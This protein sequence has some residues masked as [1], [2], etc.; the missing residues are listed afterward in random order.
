MSKDIRIKKGLSIKLKGEAEMLISDAPRSKVFAIKPTDI[1]GVIP[2]LAIKA[3]DT[4]KAGDTL[5]Y[6]K[7]NE[8][9][10]FLSPVSGEVLEIHRGAKRKILDIKIS[11]TNKDEFKDFGVKNPKDLSTGEVKEQLLAGGCWP[12]IKQRP[13]DV[14]ANPSDEPKAI[15]VSGFS[16]APLSADAAFALQG[17]EDA[18][19]AGI[20]AL[21]K[22]TS[23]KVHLSV[24]GGNATFLNNVK[25]VELHQVTGKHPAGNVGVQIH[26]IDPVNQGEHVWV[27][28]P[29]DVAIIGKLFLTGNFDAS[30]VI[31][32]AGSE[33][34]SPKYYRTIQG[35]GMDSLVNG[36]LSSEHVRIVS[37][38]VL[39]GEA[40]GQNGFLGFYHNEV[41]VIPEGD[42]YK[43]F[44]WMPF[45][46]NYKFSMSRTFFSWLTP[47][48]KYSL[49]TN[50]NG[51]LRA[52]VV[53]G[54]MEK[55]LPMDIYPMQLLKA[56]L[57]KDIE[58]ME[59][60]G[61][62]EVA[63]EDFALI[64]FSSSSKIEAQSIIREALDLMI[65]EVG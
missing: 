22:L 56:A 17:K 55:V 6:S 30:R 37:G 1:L 27:V 3:G 32:L 41:S 63:P 59:S 23:G 45:I 62:Y 15:F 34:T 35:A 5:F 19:Q 24:K 58:K 64:D 60:L 14:M 44:G 16:T 54:E 13:Y 28:N 25:G 43:M 36:H 12:F 65:K 57:A 8:Q 39:T 21:G 26:H 9:I 51:E 48:K 52:M 18:F 10:K 2:K 49:D 42:H 40:V 53:T 31:A 46:G 50:L 61:I 20:D 38:D 33:V 11:A 4:V 7:S 47:N 29:Q